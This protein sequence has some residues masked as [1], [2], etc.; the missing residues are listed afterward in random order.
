M[1]NQSYSL[2][3]VTIQSLNNKLQEQQVEVTNLAIQKADVTDPSTIK[4]SEQIQTD[5]DDLCTSIFNQFTI[6]KGNY[7]TSLI[8]LVW[9]R[10][11]L[12]DLK[13]LLV[14]R[15]EPINNKNLKAEVIAKEISRYL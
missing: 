7:E 9:Y 14:N 8:T 13:N 4:K 2:L 3:P 12:K 11:Y 1:R 5:I 10:E 6:L 15:S